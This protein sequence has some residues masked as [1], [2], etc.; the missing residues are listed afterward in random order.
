MT[1][2][3][4]RGFTAVAAL[5][6]GPHWALHTPG[7]AVSKTAF[8]ATYSTPGTARPGRGHQLPGRV[9]HHPG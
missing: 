6:G 1:S 3:V 5:A 4:R 8:P 9:H 7:I 2:T